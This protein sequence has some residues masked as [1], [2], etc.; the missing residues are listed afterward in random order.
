MPRKKD[1]PREM[2]IKLDAESIKDALSLWVRTHHGIEI[3]AKSFVFEIIEQQLTSAV[4][5]KRPRK[6]M[7]DNDGTGRTPD[8]DSQMGVL[9]GQVQT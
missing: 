2:L 9:S 1:P 5:T 8:C 7:Y 3:D 4:A 6:A